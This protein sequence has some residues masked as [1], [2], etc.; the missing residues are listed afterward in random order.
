MLIG[1]LRGMREQ[2]Q[3]ARA[4]DRPR[5]L[6]LMFRASACPTA[7]LYLPPWGEES[8]QEVY[9]LVVYLYPIYAE[10]TNVP[11]MAYGPQSFLRSN[12]QCLFPFSVSN[13]N[14]FIVHA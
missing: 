8:L 5:Q 9:I 7:R 3:V 1:V 13:M 6:P 4:F 11:V 10:C 2:S 14:P 12:S